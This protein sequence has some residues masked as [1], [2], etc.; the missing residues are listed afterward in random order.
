MANVSKLHFSQI[1]YNEADVVASKTYMIVNQEWN[2][3]VNG[4]YKSFPI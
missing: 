3:D 4:G 1:V 2:I